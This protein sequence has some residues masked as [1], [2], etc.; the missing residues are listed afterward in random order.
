MNKFPIIPDE[1]SGLGAE[2]D[3]AETST[4]PARQ[5]VVKR[6]DGFHWIAPDGRQ[7]FGPFVSL[8]AA[9]ADMIGSTDENSP[10]PGETLQEAESEIGI[11]DWIDPQTGQPAE[12]PCPPHLE[13]D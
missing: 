3:D 10:E 2:D 9:V 13:Q 6:P 11:A 4:S 7:E 8:E 5:Q 1:E 12:G